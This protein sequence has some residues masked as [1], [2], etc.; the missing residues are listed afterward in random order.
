MQ[1]DHFDLILNGNVVLE[2]VK[3]LTNNWTIVAS[4]LDI[5]FWVVFANIIHTLIINLIPLSLMKSI[6]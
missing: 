1:R 2:Q 3:Y 4:C 5:D 6:I